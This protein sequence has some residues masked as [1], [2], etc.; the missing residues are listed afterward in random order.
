MT[1]HLLLSTALLSV[2][3]CAPAA[4]AQEAV[5]VRTGS[6][7]EY[8]RLVFEWPAAPTYTVK[9]DGANLTLTFDK[10]GKAD[11]SK[12][13][14]L[15]N[16]SGVKVT[17]GAA[18]NLTLALTIPAASKIRDLKVGKRIIIDVYDPPG[19]RK[20]AVKEAPQ[21]KAAPAPVPAPKEKPPVPAAK[22]A[23]EPDA[24]KSAA[25]TEALK[26]LDA[27]EPSLTIVDEAKEKAAA[28]V[29]NAPIIQTPVEIKAQ[30]QS[31]PQ[32]IETLVTVAT[33]V[34]EQPPVSAVK[35][36][37]PVVDPHVITV[38]STKKLGLAV[39]ERGEWL[40][41]VSDDPNMNV[42]PA[43]SGPQVEK[44]GLLQRF[45][46]KGGTGYR[47][48]KTT[49]A[50]ITA[51]GGGL[52]WRIVLS[53]NPKEVQSIEPQRL[54]PV[55]AK[56]EPKT[57]RQGA[58]LLFPLEGPQKI[59][60]LT[61]PDIGDVIKVV[62]MSASTLSA[63]T[64]YQFVE[65][66]TLPS[67]VGLAYVPIADD[68]SAAIE[69][70]GVR[71]GRGSG[72]LSLS[73]DAVKEEPKKAVQSSIK[74]TEMPPVNSDN[75]YHLARWQM[76]GLR[77]L[78]DN[79]NA[80]MA[81]MA[82]KDT[83]GRVEDLLTL[84]K[85]MLANDR[86]SEALGYLRSVNL[87]M[88]EIEENAEFIGLRG[89]AALIAGQP[90][91][92]ITDMVNP[93]LDRYR[94]VPYW[95][96]ATYAA[97]EDW[98]QA[99]KSLPSDTKAINDYPPIMREWL[100]L[101]VAEVGLRAG[102]VMEAERILA[103]LEPAVGTMR[104]VDKAAWTYLMGEAARQLKQFEKGKKYWGD[105][106]KSDNEYY[107][108]RSGLALTRVLLERNEIDAA[109]AVDRLEGLRYAWRGDELEALTNYRLGQVYIENDEYLKGLHVLRNAATLAPASQLSREVTAYMTRSFRTLF[110]SDELQKLSPLE[111]IGVYEEFKELMPPE[112][113]GDRIV[114]Q[115]AERMVDTDL[116]ARAESL[117]DYQLTHRLK[118]PEAGRIALRLAAIRLLNNKP[119]VALKNLAQAE[120]AYKESDTKLV[121]PD[122]MREITLLRASALAKA[123][124]ADKAIDEISKLPADKTVARLRADIAWKSQRWRE[125]ADGL[126]SLIDVEQIR[127]DIALTPDQADLI[128]NRGIALNLAGD[129]VGLGTLRDRYSAQM[130]QTPKNELFDVVT[131]PRR[132]G[133]IRSRDT[134]AETINNV[135]LFKDFLESYRKV[136]VMSPASVTMP[137]ATA[138]A[139]KAA[140]PAAAATA[141]TT[142]EVTP[143]PAAAPPAEPVAETDSAPVSE[144]ATSVP[145][146]QAPTNTTPAPT[147]EAATSAPA[148]AAPAPAPA[149]QTA[150]E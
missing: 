47:L 149:A 116:L 100:S 58:A 136:E 24:V 8:Q 97:L 44:F 70:G 143:A 28:P 54:T 72:D 42:P 3:A 140:T 34:V 107:R 79:Q 144:A 60:E 120:A 45:D 21:E 38:T 131:L 57:E 150:T 74:K 102:Q 5:D 114:E 25:P 4:W 27:E 113:E 43:L 46:V 61:D 67:Y 81:G 145:A 88:P 40:W 104:P 7:D 132:F 112:Q 76:G 135:D 17:S 137:E 124:Q 35:E 147:P 41:V 77:A 127:P 105:L 91:L 126:Q 65:L 89:A 87:L 14:A 68:V 63:R 51:E 129:R 130:K 138:S 122:T 92:A 94:D 86:G 118:G 128:L 31:A 69:T 71:I 95:R 9:R 78:A 56:A 93:M 19:G 55:A 146:A 111:A 85:L 39:F 141:P 119:E 103:D 99:I 134:I 123:G 13:K 10:P 142:P 82:G 26:K 2:L 64:P 6:Q 106:A 98:Q 33:P 22:T 37:V 30:P 101:N 96:M 90:D 20:A 50:G 16:I 36:S 32:A 117:Y 148:E 75:L 59:V 108:A 1:R 115:L 52:R 109:Q 49:G 83:A 11:I 62:T 139:S 73:M 23:V 15:E 80:L 110:D 53:P 48:K 121:P 29:T 84:S 66:E 12:V 125:A 133:L 18:D